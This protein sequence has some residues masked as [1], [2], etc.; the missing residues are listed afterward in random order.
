MAITFNQIMDRAAYALDKPFDHILK[1]RFINA[2]KLELANRIHQ[3]IDKNGI[4]KAM[5]SRFTI[6]LIKVDIADTCIVDYNCT[7]LRSEYRVPSPVRYK[8]DEPFVF[9]GSP[10]GFITFT[11]TELHELEDSKYLRYIGDTIRYNYVNGFI[12]VFNNTKFKYAAVD[13]VYVDPTSLTIC[14][15]VDEAICLDNDYAMPYPDDMINEI[16]S[17]LLKREFGLVKTD[18]KEVDT[19]VNN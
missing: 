8:S 11:Y 13:G 19:D 15:S 2:F 16:I 6:E 1:E 7:V 12:Y 17:T 4:D 9:V 3:A 10:D 14:N 18:N 5:R